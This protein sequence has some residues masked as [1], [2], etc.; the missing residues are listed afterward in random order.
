M[1]VTLKY[2]H[3][4]HAPFQIDANM[5]FT[6]AVYEM[7]MYSDSDKIKILPA[8]PSEWESGSIEGIRARGGYIVSIYWSKEEV[9][10]K[11]TSLLGGSVNVGI[12]GY[13][14]KSSLPSQESKYGDSYR[15]ITLS[16]GESIELEYSK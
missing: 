7:L 15:Y 5:G 13:T 9:R 4:G 11:L 3:A 16:K 8:K 2:L 1:G 10:V 12:N 6:S 14:L